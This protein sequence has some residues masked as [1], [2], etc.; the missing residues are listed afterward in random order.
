M[1][2]WAFRIYA[3]VRCLGGNIQATRRVLPY[4]RNGITHKFELDGFRY[5]ATFSV[6]EDNALAEIFLSSAKTGEL[7]RTI[8][9]DSAI[10]ASLAL[11]YG[12]PVELLRD[13]L[14]RNERGDAE[15]PLAAAL[16]LFTTGKEPP[17]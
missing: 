9:R 2:G 7:L 12:C 6:Y 3:A 13:A 10:A 4:R 15:S 8:N 16:D 14:G 11:Q 17:K 5:Y 1:R